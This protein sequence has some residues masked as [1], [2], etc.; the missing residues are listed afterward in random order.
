MTNCCKTGNLKPLGQ[1]SRKGQ[2]NPYIFHQ[3]PF[4]KRVITALFSS[5]DINAFK[6]LLHW[7]LISEFIQ[8]NPNNETLIVKKCNINTNMFSA[9]MTK[10]EGSAILLGFAQLCLKKLL[11]RIVKKPHSTLEIISKHRGFQSQVSFHLGVTGLIQVKCSSLLYF[12]KYSYFSYIE[13]FF[14]CQTIARIVPQPF[15]FQIKRDC[16]SKF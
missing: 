11:E 15:I 3:F 6:M 13:L 9:V 10:F 12:L 4:I 2:K 16:C 14:I 1:E 7:K 8:E 5:S